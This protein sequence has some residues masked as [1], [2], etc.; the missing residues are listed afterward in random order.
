MSRSPCAADTSRTFLLGFG[1]Y[2]TIITGLLFFH[3]NSED[4]TSRPLAVFSA[5][6]RP[7]FY[8][9]LLF[10]HR[11]FFSSRVLQ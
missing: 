7:F 9:A 2:D 8:L 3:I 1:Q 6:G 4:N 5:T 10:Q 11:L